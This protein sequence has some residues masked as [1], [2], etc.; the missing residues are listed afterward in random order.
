M[1]S[2]VRNSLWYLLSTDSDEARRARRRLSVGLALALLV[3]GLLTAVGLAIV[4]FA[5][6]ARHFFFRP[7]MFQF[8][9][10]I[11]G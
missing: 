1:E 5:N 10:R 6:L 2:P 7:R 4:V 3:S 8:E 9:R 11:D